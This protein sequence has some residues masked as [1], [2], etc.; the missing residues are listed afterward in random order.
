MARKRI[1]PTSRPADGFRAYDR[2]R[3]TNDDYDYVVANPNDEMTGVPAYEA[4]GWEIERKG[5]GSAVAAVGKTVGDG[6]AVTVLGGVVMKRLKSFGQEEFAHGQAIADSLERRIS[7]DGHLDG[8]RVAKGVKVGLDRS[9]T[10][11][12][13]EELEQGA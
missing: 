12:P 3:N 1:D 9:V 5:P 2:L 11:A 6:E 10:T 7:K 13:Y 4:V 8:E